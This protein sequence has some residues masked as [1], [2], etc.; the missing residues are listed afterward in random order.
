MSQY[1]LGGFVDGG[2][3]VFTSNCINISIMYWLRTSGNVDRQ[4]F[5]AFALQDLAQ[6][7]PIAASACLFLLQIIKILVFELGS[8]RMDLIGFL[9][10][11]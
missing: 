1:F 4:I 10:A 3:S 5:I 8:R 9:E 6:F 2:A 7:G 11:S